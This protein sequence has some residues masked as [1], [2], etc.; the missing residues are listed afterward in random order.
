MMFAL[1]LATMVT[2][3][4]VRRSCHVTT[5]IIESAV[6]HDKFGNPKGDNNDLGGSAFNADG[7]KIYIIDLYTKWAES[8]GYANPHLGNMTKGLREKGFT[9]SV[10]Q[11]EP[12]TT[13]PEQKG[14]MKPISER[15]NQIKPSQLWIIDSADTNAFTKDDFEAIKKFYHEGNSL[16][17]SADN[18]P[19]N[20]N[21]NRLANELIKSTVS[22]DYP[23]NVVLEPKMDQGV[24]GFVKNDITTGINNLYV[25]RT[26]AAITPPKNGNGVFSP[27]M[28]DVDA[29][30]Q[31]FI[32]V[33]QYEEN[34]VAQYEENAG[35]QSTKR[36]IIDGGFTRLF[37]Q[38]YNNSSGTE[39]FVRNCA[40]WLSGKGKSLVNQGAYRG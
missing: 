30:G 13:P 27:V 19:F 38:F 4:R 39:R 16:L 18:D 3:R 17:L 6:E 33:A 26:I 36:L 28:Y 8:K 29:Y 2:G 9:V 12:S 5:P 31:P 10:D 15:L 25:G 34:V 11:L 24:R 20:V 7:D 1:S 32:V 14:P 35:E 22:G 21:V 40:V 37:G 23:G